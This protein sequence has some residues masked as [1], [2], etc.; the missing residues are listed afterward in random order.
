MLISNMAVEL[1]E[2]TPPLF[3]LLMATMSHKLVKN[4]T[5]YDLQNKMS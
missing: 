5:D 4:K 3:I 2:D 1:P